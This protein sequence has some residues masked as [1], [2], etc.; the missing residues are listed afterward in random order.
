MSEKIDEARGILSK[1]K[2]KNPNNIYIKNLRL[3][4]KPVTAQDILNDKDLFEKLV[5]TPDPL[6]K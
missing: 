1:F 4:E 3:V 6:Q 2:Q 5:L